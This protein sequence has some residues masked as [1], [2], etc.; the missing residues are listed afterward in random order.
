MLGAIVFASG[1]FLFL[2]NMYSTKGVLIPSLGI[3]IGITFAFLAVSRTAMLAEITCLIVL[4]VFAFK[5]YKRNKAKRTSVR[6]TLL[7]TAAVIIL[8]AS[9]GIKMDD[10]YY[11]ALER[12]NNTQNTEALDN[13]VQSSQPEVD[14]IEKFRKNW[15]MEDIFKQFKLAW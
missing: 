12:N 10:I 14:E 13:T 6:R 9:I 2:D 8:V 4:I 1:S 11:Y 7:V 15:A 5:Q 3:G